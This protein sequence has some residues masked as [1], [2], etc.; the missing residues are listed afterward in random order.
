V[1]GGNLN[2]YLR[3]KKY[4]LALKKLTV[5]NVVN[6]V[7]A[8]RSA[9]ALVSIDANEKRPPRGV[10]IATCSDTPKR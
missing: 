3:L 6:M 9:D 1:E 5:P 7:C 8:L 2:G 4:E 10:R